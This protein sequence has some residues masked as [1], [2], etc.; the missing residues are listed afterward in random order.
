MSPND[1]NDEDTFTVMT[2]HSIDYLMIPS[3][4]KYLEC[5]GYIAQL[6]HKSKHTVK[7]KLETWIKRFE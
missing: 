2:H 5:Y 6:L 3:R 4:Y 1:V 7:A